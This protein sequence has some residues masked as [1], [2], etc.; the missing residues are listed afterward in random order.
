MRVL[1]L[2]DDLVVCEAVVGS[3]RRRRGFTISC[4]GVSFFCT[5]VCTLV[6]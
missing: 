2:N 1:V 3:D 4:T 5:I 6:V